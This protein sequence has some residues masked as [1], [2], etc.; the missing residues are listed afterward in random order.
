MFGLHNPNLG[1]QYTHL[2][3]TVITTLMALYRGARRDDKNPTWH[4][5]GS[6]LGA[7]VM[8]WITYMT[9]AWN[10]ILN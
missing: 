6:V 5:I 3:L 2:T 8:N 7:A 1:A 9:G 10:L 4:F